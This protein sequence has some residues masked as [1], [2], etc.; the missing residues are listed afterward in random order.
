MNLDF[1]P[2]ARKAPSG[3]GLGSILAPIRIDL[4]SSSDLRAF[5]RGLF[6]SDEVLLPEYQEVDFAS[7]IRENER[8]IRENYIATAETVRQRISITPAA[9]WLLDNHHIVEE[10]IR[11]VRRDLTRNF[12]RILPK[13]TVPGKGSTPRIMALAWLYVAHTNSDFSP[14]SL[15]E[16]IS[17]FQERSELTI[18]ELWAAPAF[19]RYVMIENL[20][21]LS[22]RVR[23]AR[24][25]RSE[26][27]RLA[28]LLTAEENV[29]KRLELMQRKANFTQDNTF[30]AQLLYRFRDGSQWAAQALEW[31]ESMLE[32]R[33]SHGEAV[34][35]AEQNRQSSG[36]LTTGNIIT[37][38]RRIDDVYW[39]GW[40]ESLS[41]VD[42]TLQAGS[43]FSLLDS[44]TRNRYRDSIEAIARRGKIP[45]TSVAKAAIDLAASSASRLDTG[46]DP[47]SDVGYFLVGKGKPQ[48]RLTVGSPAPFGSSLLRRYRSWGWFAAGFPN[49]ATTLA[50]IAL[51]ATFLAYNGVSLWAA[52]PLLILFALPASD[53]AAA[54][55]QT[56]AALVFKPD[57][58]PGYELKD[59]IPDHARTLVAIPCLITNHDTVDELVR[60][61]ELH[62]LAN[63]QGAVLFALL[64]DWRD[65]DHEETPADQ[66]IL[67]YAQQEIDR[68]DQ[69]YPRTGRRFYLLHRKRQFNP[70]EGVWMGWERKRGKLHEL[71]LL[72]RGD[73][74]TSY[75]PPAQAL[76]DDVKYVLTVDSDT[77][78][79]LNSVA[80]LV[81]KAVH[82]L[83]R[84]VYSD[85]KGRV[86]SGYTIFQPRVTASLTTGAEASPFQRTFSANR[87]FDPYVFTVSDF[88]Q[89]LVGEGSFTG[90]GLYEVDSFER[91][92]RG[93]IGD[94]AVL[95][96]DLLEGSYARCALVTDVE[97]VED[98]PIRYQVEASRQH[99]WARGDWQLLPFIFG[100]GNGLTG[101]GRLKMIDNLRRSFAP[102]GWVT[103]SVIAWSALP[104][105]VAFVW[106]VFMLLGLAVAP[107]I[108]FAR[109]SVPSRIGVTLGGHL[110]TLW[111]SLYGT[112]A[113]IALRIVFMAHLA[114][115][116]ADAVVRALWRLF[117]SKKHLLEWR[118]AAQVSSGG[119][120]SLMGHYKMMAASPIIGVAS[121]IFIALENP[122]NLPLA[123]IFSIV[124][125]A[126]PAIAW[127][128]SR[129]QETEDHLELSARD[130]LFL[131][132]TAR[133]TWR[134]FETF[135]TTE[136][137]FLP[138][139]NFQED[140]EPVVAERTSP[141]NIGLYL[142]STITAKNFGWI[143]LADAVQRM[144]Q[145]ISTVERLPKFNGHL[146]NWYDIRS[147]A[148]LPPGY[149]SAVDSGNLAGHLVT[150]SSALKNW[151]QAPASQML[152]NFD[153]VADV[154]SILEDSVGAIPDVRKT[155]QPIRQRY[156]ERLGGLVANLDSWRADPS[157]APIKPS[158]L[159]KTARELC[160]L[161]EALIVG[162]E[163]IESDTEI[164]V[165]AKELR[166]WCSVLLATA[167]ANSMDAI[168]DSAD[169]GQWELRLG[170]LAERARSIAFAMD[171]RFLMDKDR[172]LLS[173]GYRADNKELDKSCYDLLASE[174]RLTSLFAIAKGDLPKEHWFRL[175]RPVTAVRWQAA[176]VS[177]SGSMFEYLMPPLVMHEREGGILNQSNRL[178][179]ARQIEYAKPF[180]VPW[181]I[182]E[183]AFNTRDRLMNYQYQ[184][185]GVPSLGLKH[186]LSANLVIAPYATALASQF[187]PHESIVNMERLTDA[188][189]LGLYGYY[190]A[191]DYT[192]SRLLEGQK[193][194][195]VKNYLA[196]HQG[197]SIAAIGN[198]VL[199]GR[200]REYFHAD[201]VIE[202]A[203][204]LLQERAPREVVSVTRA[205]HLEDRPTGYTDAL[206]LQFVRIDDPLESKRSTSVL[207]NGRYSV[208]VT[209]SGS[210]YSRW[211]DLAVTRWR[212]DPTL[213][214]FGTYIFLRD[215][216]S[217]KWWSATAEPKQA[218]AEK[219]FTIFAD[220]RAEFHKN[221]NGLDTRL[222]VLVCSGSDGEGRKLTIMN[223]SERD[224]F[225]EVTSFGECV[226]SRDDSDIAHP[227]FSKM[228]VKT[229]IGELGDVIYATRNKRSPSDADIII[230]H[231]IADGS[232]EQ[233][234]TQAETDRRAFIGR[235]RNLGCAAAF[236]AG[237]RLGGNSGYTMDP[238]FSL[239]RTFRVPAGKEIS[240]NFWTIAAPDRAGLDRAV[241]HYRRA[242]TF[243]HETTLA[244]TRSQVQIRHIDMTPQE[245][246]NFQKFASF[247]IY[248]DLRLRPQEVV[249]LSGLKSQ[250]SLWP[251]SISGDYP[252]FSLRIDGEAEIGSVREA[253]RMQE[254]LRSRGII[255]DLVIINERVFSY[256]QDLNN[257]I[258][259]LCEN[260]SRRGLASGPGQHIF[261]V[262]RDLMGEETWAALIASSRIA[263]HT[264]NGKLSEQLARLEKTE[265]EGR[266]AKPAPLAR[267]PV[268]ASVTSTAVTS[269]DG[270]E[271]WN[272][273]GGFDPN[274]RAYVVRLPAGGATPHP[275]IN[276]VSG[277]DFGFH[278]SAEGAGY[279]W[280]ANSRDFQ[281]TPWSNDTVINRPSEGIHLLDLDT[282]E[283][284]SP[285][286][287]LSVDKDAVFEARH[288]PG[289][290]EFSTNTSGLA[291]Q[292]DQTV[293]QQD[294][295]KHTRLRIVNKSQKP[296]RLRVFSWAELVLGNNP[297]RSA[298][299]VTAQFDEARGILT[300]S[301]RY[302]LDYGGRTTFMTASQPVVY[303]TA[304]RA[305][306][307]GRSGSVQQP[308][309]ARADTWLQ[310]SVDTQGDPMV[311][312]ACD[313]ELKV[314][315]TREIILHFGDAPDSVVDGVVS[316]LSNLNYDA[317]VE[318]SDAKWE[319]F[320][321]TLQVQT[322]DKALDRMVNTWLPYQNI[323]CR[324]Q[325]RAAFY[326]ASGAFGFRDQLQDTAA[327]IFH[328][329]RL[330][331]AQILNAAS[332]QFVEGDVQHWWLPATGAGVRT[333]ISD[334][335]VWLA[336]CTAHYIRTTG[337]T[338]VLDEKV[339]F[340]T[341]AALE[342]GKHDSF[343]KPDISGD[344]ASLYEHCAKALELAIARTGP[345]GIPLILG[346]DWNDGMNRVGEHGTG[347]SV[348]LGWFLATTLKQ[349]ARIAET[350]GDKERAKQWKAHRKMLIVAMEANAWD[351]DHYLRGFYDDGTPLGANA[352][353]ECKIDSIAQSWSVLSGA[354]RPER[355]TMA[356]D[357]VMSRLFDENAGV[358]RLFTPP[359]EHT[360]KDPGYIKGYPP[361]VRENGGQYTHA[362]TWVVYAL[363]QMGRGDDAYKCFSL[364]NPV[365]HATDRESADQYRVEPYVVAADVYGEGNKTGR[366]GWTWY[367]G[368]AGW[369]W[370][371]AVEAILGMQLKDGRLS[372]TPA[373][374]AEWEGFSANLRK[375]GK[376]FA[377]VVNQTAKGEYVTTV[378]G[379]KSTREAGSFD[380]G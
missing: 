176:L 106:Q 250:S 245:A 267:I 310:S 149:I 301:N 377:I 378:N 150:V 208:M 95:S 62:Y 165:P 40:F 6:G 66:E 125:V 121:F 349:F 352:E 297:A 234:E 84:P 163:S 324:V 48:L 344:K 12:Y 253:L 118:T 96:H 143:S 374:P 46:T 337:D 111:S 190:D 306:Y 248:P 166:H 59:G 131:R 262:R 167:Q 92:L 315:E 246:A 104:A 162:T 98:F 354:A 276:V 209:A 73:K 379:A 308:Q 18:G 238:V 122:A 109:Q 193:C 339:N 242:E 140:P 8:Q 70:G 227:A 222:E 259:A 342:P 33:G 321:C 160:E 142:L 11:H 97:F 65:S 296:R 170:A 188:G 80:A 49:F 300:A 219:S 232:G 99:R 116:L 5:G 229:E 151:A 173:I 330:A 156:T 331:R 375:N 291:L 194:A 112:I 213:D 192:A 320:L 7:R 47:R 189:A 203:E 307:F 39:Q 9:E 71:N 24:D 77:R 114:Y 138:P 130:Q 362:A 63:P 309:A 27:N 172:R 303:H 72:L 241:M 295:V 228:F 356:M 180:D 127:N 78:L 322:P 224:R 343:Y 51:A 348:W 244:W 103:S 335:V 332:R 251:M 273:Y 201:P 256:A 42:R 67:A 174:A 316:R 157:S 119:Q 312:I 365:N 293:S 225:I 115:V 237:A 257:I 178:A 54:F 255:S 79:P 372:I 76:P 179:I 206:G 29:E 171:F 28:D 313:I 146:Y 159:V 323:A 19:L 302:S 164:S 38:L 318:Q 101:I 230:G 74:D 252:I 175:G 216:E 110:R 235:G 325:A 357:A 145:T 13:W 185:F 287:G 298:P 236:D 304:A 214:Q 16:F 14:E 141:T 358:L 254:Y 147:L 108:G 128:V 4:W 35:V 132:K 212:P 135:V 249:A 17:G 368:S 239:R 64:S 117:F 30:A 270:L 2:I 120:A 88:Y 369:L 153:G 200:L 210:G 272:G 285:F 345:H 355:A 123:A 52:L 69:S 31:L 34:V 148:I 380:L 44:S 1:L 289:R 94:N 280:S 61:L 274:S 261:S 341:G 126:A 288:L 134:Y 266:L 56:A 329:P 187:R 124:W 83:N 68:L 91:S 279:T 328:D 226:L 350:R 37:S 32:A 113:E 129:S 45:E 202:A 136:L 326:Q 152:A 366:G 181:G 23:N 75:F 82:P 53:A 93:K 371:S 220:H 21:R 233:R 43:D 154:A 25:M 364:L 137:N 195:I 360:E 105:S 284:M 290:S 363:A 155:V 197:M 294:P 240:V 361:G 22:D 281:L 41:A 158:D 338:L 292:V 346:G 211:N 215:I 231:M 161:A 317:L 247:L 58:L 275:W 57:H 89:D 133:K 169:L 191:V 100:I 144:E 86:V 367:T 199:N 60:N 282:N 26:A 183:S 333:I 182:S 336:Y 55:V 314:G 218:E 81:G 268:L 278:V 373:L 269:G 205:G 264:R 263:L 260:A 20:R 10:N 207:S 258:S 217:G 299:F 370:R 265:E 102:V 319:D 204:L 311:A 327:L 271:H 15:T 243:A 340:L 376:A 353:P 359:F 87:G 351:G 305:E 283:V 334:D 277:R 85:A 223:R 286:A 196:H 90:K 36:N 184:N 221:A 168:A 177:W 50:I 198:A 186:D 139:D 347:E 107:L 3:P